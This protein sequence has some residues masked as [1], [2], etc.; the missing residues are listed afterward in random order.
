MTESSSQR[1]YALGTG[2]SVE[3]RAAM[4]R[5]SRST[6]WAVLDTSRPG[7]FLR[8]TYRL[9]EGDVSWYVGLDWPKPN[10]RHVQVSLAV[11][12]YWDCEWLQL[13]SSI[14]CGCSHL[15]DIQRDLN[16]GHVPGDPRLQGPRVNRMPHAAGHGVG[17]G[18]SVPESWQQLW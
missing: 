6:L 4:M 1:Q 17:C 2:T 13:Q 14:G 10:C 11:E 7:G 5:Y 15:L 18:R 9:P 3:A 16:L 8:S 12:G